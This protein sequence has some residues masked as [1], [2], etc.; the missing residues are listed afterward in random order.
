[1]AFPAGMATNGSSTVGS[2]SVL[3]KWHTSVEESERVMSS[4][5]HFMAMT[6]T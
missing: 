1:M 4:S 3:L 6:L 5:Q 2:Q